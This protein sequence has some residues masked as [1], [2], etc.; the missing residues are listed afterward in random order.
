[1][2]KNLSLKPYANYQDLIKFIAIILMFIDHISYYFDDSLLMFRV[3]GRP[4]MAIFCFL[5]GYNYKLT[6]N[7]NIIA[8]GFL[9]LVESYSIRHSLQID[10]ILVPI[11]LGQ[12]YISIFHSSLKKFFPG[13]IHF[14]I[15]G[16]IAPFIWQYCWYGTYVIAIMVLGYHANY[17]KTN[18]KLGWILALLLSS[19]YA[20]DIFDFLM[21]AI[22]NCNFNNTYLISLLALDVILYYFLTHKDLGAPISIDLKLISRNALYIYFFSVIVMEYSWLYLII[23]K[24]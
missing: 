18:Y 21:I 3:I 23:T 20:L 22:V 6:P 16:F 12:C 19:L 17:D 15:L 8:L 14:I 13:F 9:M 11:F 5:A 2:N 10:N 4:V 24:H 7:F 1:M